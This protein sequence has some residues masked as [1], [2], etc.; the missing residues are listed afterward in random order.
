MEDIMKIIKTLEETGL[1]ILIKGASGTIENEKK[2]EKGGF[3]NM[4]VGILGANLSGNLIA[5]KGV[6]A[7]RG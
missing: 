2:E 6:K 4:F 5:G 3:L 7:N 1:L